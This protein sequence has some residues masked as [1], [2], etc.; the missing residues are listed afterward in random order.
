MQSAL[1]DAQA[2]VNRNRSLV[3]MKV[4]ANFATRSNAKDALKALK[5]AGFE[6]ATIDVDVRPEQV[7][8][9]SENPPATTNPSIVGLAA[10]N[11]GVGGTMGLGNAAPIAP[12]VIETLEA[13]ATARLTVE[14]GSR[15]E[16]AAQIIRDQGG[17]IEN[18]RGAIASSTLD[19]VANAA[20]ARNRLK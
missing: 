11:G 5:D 20:Q 16:E 10:V 15:N 3:H 1:K 7:E 2:P 9:V 4:T 14:A 6:D 8:A 19:E 12:I 13:N 18:E 17:D